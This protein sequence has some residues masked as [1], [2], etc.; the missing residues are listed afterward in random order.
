MS[1]NFLYLAI[2]Y[3][4]KYKNFNVSLLIRYFNKKYLYHI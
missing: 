2:N 1:T 3:Y 4:K